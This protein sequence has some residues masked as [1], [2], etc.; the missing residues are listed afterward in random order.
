MATKLTLRFPHELRPDEL[1]DR[2]TNM[3]ER[4]ASAAGGS[5]GVS[6][7]RHGDMYPFTW[8]HAGFNID[9]ELLVSETE[10]T[11]TVEV[12]WIARMFQGGLEE[13]I[14]RQAAVL[15]QQPKT[16]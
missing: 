8:R 12:P 5:D 6:Y 4:Q 9:G 1:H 10:M 3:V 16:A 14:R 13:I 11:V 7:H 2:L 15:I